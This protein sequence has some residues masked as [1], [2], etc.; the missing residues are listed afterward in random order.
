MK[1]LPIIAV[2]AIC[3]CT[4][5]KPDFKVFTLPEGGSESACEALDCRVSQSRDGGEWTIKVSARNDGSD[6]AVFKLALEAEPH[7]KADSWLIPGIIYD[8]NHYGQNMPQGWELDC[9]PWVFSYDRGSIPSC[10]I[11]ENAS[12]V[13]ALFA[14]DA[15]TAS[16]VSSCSMEKLP[17]GSFRHLIYWPVTE[18]PL[19]YSGKQK[20]TERYDTYLTLAPGERFEASAIAC[21]GK[22]RWP[23]YG[24]AE[25]FPVAWKRLRHEVPAQRSLQEVMRL[26]KAFQ[27]WSRRKDENGFWYGG[28]VDDQVFC[29]GYYKSGKSPDGYTLEDY[30]AH[31][32]LNRWATDEIADSKLLGPGEI[33][34]GHGRDLGFA[35]QSYQM[36]RL[37]MEY[38]FRNGSPDDVD[39]GLKVLRSWIANRRG[40]SGLFHGYKPGPHR[41]TNASRTGWAIS[42]LSRVSI[43]MREH[44]LD[45]SEF[46]RVAAELAGVV[47]RN[48][49]EDGNLGSV[50]NLETGEVESWGG[51]GGG[52][53]LL[54]LVRWWQLTQ[55]DS[56][57]PVF[58][59]IFDYYYN[60][61][62]DFFRC[63]GG[64]M[65]C[66]SVDREG[67]HPFLTAA[68]ILYRE[69]GSDKYLERALKA[70]WYFLSWL[71]IQNPLY[72]PGTDL[73]DLG[74]KPA[75][76]TIVGA[77][78]PALDEY[79]CVL[80]PDFFGLS[81]ATGD[82]LW[83]D[84]AALVWRN[85][86]QGF[87]NEDHRI[88]HGLE[89]PV[90]S[91][92]EA[93]FPSRWSKYRLGEKAR[94]SINDHLT[95]WGGT[96]RLA[97]IYDLSE[98][99]LAW[100]DA[101]TK[102]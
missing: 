89:R 52:Y 99:E 86:T 43:L 33:L 92:N 97:S 85:S 100:L 94:G 77:E 59:R 84:V 73:Y 25:V 45:P 31:P 10:T 61:D 11:S 76:A 62:I 81:K 16:Y 102:P 101:V 70:G 36:A 63:S 27:D 50:W 72:A 23:G 3:A 54:G 53:V 57:L 71:Y 24:F 37:S 15:D 55:D 98:G 29:A 87:A 91:K 5:L 51:D 44:G 49:R 95:A 2:A 46:E 22:P 47:L 42:E 78:H 88:W 26:D 96:Y 4:P 19:T 60:K 79:A 20:F 41:T 56:L 13:F 21:T 7:I 93:I 68:M 69:T 9:E 75:G 74:W 34:Y 30:D 14:S 65:D 6:T 67:I 1:V 8:G 82:P 17:D 28:I 12:R 80:I 32:E 18:A 66:V 58:D 38:G 48:M 64:A 40:A 90:G 35:A 83:K 39:F